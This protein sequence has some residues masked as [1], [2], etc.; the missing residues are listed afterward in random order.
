[1][2]GFRSIDRNDEWRNRIP[3]LQIQDVVVFGD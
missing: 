3:V 2:Y 1:M